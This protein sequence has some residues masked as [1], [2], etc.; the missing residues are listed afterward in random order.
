MITLHSS[1]QIWQP[2]YLVLG[3]LGSTIRRT[4]LCFVFLGN[5]KIPTSHEFTSRKQNW[6]MWSPRWVGSTVL[7]CMKKQSSPRNGKRHKS[8]DILWEFSGNPFFLAFSPQRCWKKREKHSHA[9]RG[10]KQKTLPTEHG[11]HIFNICNTPS[12]IMPI[13]TNALCKNWCPNGAY[14]ISKI[15]IFH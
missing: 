2:G 1:P 11:D 12:A 4:H 5:S 14:E 3:G 10:S 6:K 8:D 13:L 7:K 15:A 9:A